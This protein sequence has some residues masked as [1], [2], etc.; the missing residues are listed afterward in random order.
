MGAIGAAIKM[1]KIGTGDVKANHE[2]TDLTQIKTLL[3]FT[4]KT[5]F[6]V[7]ASKGREARRGAG[8]LERRAIWPNGIAKTHHNEARDRPN[9]AHRRRL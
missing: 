4:S 7:V 1:A 3:S 5:R 9:P 2:K 6:A 8:P